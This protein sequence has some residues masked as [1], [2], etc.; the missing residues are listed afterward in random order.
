[1][2]DGPVDVYDSNDDEEMDK[3]TRDWTPKNCRPPHIG[4]KKLP[5]AKTILKAYKMG[6]KLAVKKLQYNQEYVLIELKF[7]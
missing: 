3:A 6:A 4:N 7:Y 1:M 2:D 5:F